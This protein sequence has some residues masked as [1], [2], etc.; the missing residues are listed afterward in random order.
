LQ[1]FFLRKISVSFIIVFLALGFV[2]LGIRLPTL[3]GL[4]S[5]A[6]PKPRP[7]A[8]VDNQIKTCKN[9]INSIDTSSAVVRHAHLQMPDMHGTPVFTKTSVLHSF[10]FIPKRFSRAPPFVS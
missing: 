3:P 6:K 4:S 10:H 5:P 7:R 9:V 2:S 8:I 1:K